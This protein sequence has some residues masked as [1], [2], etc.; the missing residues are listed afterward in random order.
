MNDRL[1]KKIFF[2]LLALLGLWGCGNN[3]NKGADSNATYDSSMTPD[4]DTTGMST[5]DSL[6]NDRT[7]SLQRQP[8]PARPE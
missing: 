7:D 1:M 2:T 6:G 3:S 5:N 4:V 8:S